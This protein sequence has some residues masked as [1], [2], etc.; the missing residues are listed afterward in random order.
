MPLQSSSASV[1]LAGHSPGEDRWRAVV[2]CFKEMWD[3]RGSPFLDLHMMLSFAHGKVTQ[4][5]ARTALADQLMKVRTCACTVHVC[6]QLLFY[7][8][9]FIIGVN[10]LFED[11][12]AALD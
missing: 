11:W 9:G 8:Q 4:C 6:I 7:P 5:A 10:C 3:S 12:L 2:D 1:Q